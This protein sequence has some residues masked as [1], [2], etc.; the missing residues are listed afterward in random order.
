MSE[1][2]QN[3]DAKLRNLAN[4]V[5]DAIRDKIGDDEYNILRAK[6]QKKLL[7]KRAERKKTIAIDKILHPVQAAMRSKGIRDRKKSA[8][9]KHMDP[10]K[11]HGFVAKKKKLRIS[12]F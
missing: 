7:I 3:I 6:I 9:R 10:S 4:H 12:E 8:K 2:D 5:G 11:M 1:E